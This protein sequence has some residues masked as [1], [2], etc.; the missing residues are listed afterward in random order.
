VNY[1]SQKT[2]Y[3]RNLINS[4]AQNA[5]GELKFPVPK[6]GIMHGIDD[7]YTANNVRLQVSYTDTLFRHGLLNAIGGAEMRD[8]E[9]RDRA[10]W[11][12]GFNPDLGTATPVD[13]LNAYPEYTTGA[14]I[15]LS[16]L[17]GTVGT[18]EHYLSYYAIAGYSWRG[19]YLI[20]ASAR[21]DESNLFGVRTNQKGVPLW[22]GGVAWD[23]SKERFYHVKGIPFLKLRITD[24][25]TG[26]IDRNL[27]AYTTANVNG[28]VNGYG[29]TTATIIN[30][31]N[32][33]LRW[34]RINIVNV[35]A[36]FATSGGKFGGTVEYFIKT[37]VDLIGPTLIDPT[38]GV[39]VFQEN[40]ANMR[41][42]GVDLT[43][44]TDHSI[45]PIRWNSVLLFS[46]VLDKVTNYKVQL[47]SVG[48][49][50]NP[51]TIN[52]VLGHPLYSVYA[53]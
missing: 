28:G 49:Y 16:Y 7:S 44:H 47:G 29:A 33:N 37:G 12:Y 4:F 23:I 25:Y 10:N 45:G 15:Q 40:S 50:L 6:G 38:T 51:A 46:Y 35:G 53:L 2:Y 5:G 32:P 8:I 1:Y 41:D 52:P 31:P 20:S 3:A 27:S 13:Y 9:G 11:Q 18:S 43:L 30:P 14:P 24:G 21:R 34:E 19:R 42:H 36:D 17:D 22:S 48:N 26:N 39:S